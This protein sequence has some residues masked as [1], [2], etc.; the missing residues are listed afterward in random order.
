MKK[1]LK[2]GVMLMIL[3]M[4]ITACTGGGAP[5]EESS[6]TSGS[7]IKIITQ[8]ADSS[9][10]ESTEASSETSTEA[11]SETSTESSS[12]PSAESS[13]PSSEASQTESSET[14]SEASQSE[15]SETSGESGSDYFTYDDM[16]AIYQPV[17]D[18]SQMVRSTG[19]GGD[20]FD[21][22]DV[23]RDSGVDMSRISDDTWSMHFFEQRID[24]DD[25][26]HLQFLDVD[27]DGDFELLV[28][29]PYDEKGIYGIYTIIDGKPVA[30]LI[31]WSRNCF[32]VDAYGHIFMRGSGGAGESMIVKMYLKD[33]EVYVSE[34][35]LYHWNY[36]SGAEEY[37][38]RSE[39]IAEAVP[40]DACSEEQ[41]R[42]LVTQWE[43]SF[44]VVYVRDY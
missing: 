26:I 37:Y 38:Y 19:F 4:L 31:G 16:I 10:T 24:A 29:N 7:G 28:A 6:Q 23:L 17:I 43:S 13:E 35:I 33:E 36:E 2:I 18:V 39:G 8:D 9:K 20:E 40:E 25:A 3:T 44:T 42:D 41:Y 27:N 30:L 1:Q 12:E 11:S 14:S 22:I 5:V 15:S 34:S 32:Y 21:A